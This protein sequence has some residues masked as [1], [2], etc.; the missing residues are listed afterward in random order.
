MR[1]VFPTRFPPI[2]YLSLQSTQI[3]G[4][5]FNFIQY[6]YASFLDLKRPCTSYSYQFVYQCQYSTVAQSNIFQQGGVR[7]CLNT[8]IMYI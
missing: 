2:V 8:D 6:K 5:F 3:R 4:G 1:V 7:T